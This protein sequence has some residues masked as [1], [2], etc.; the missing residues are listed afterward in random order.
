MNP[1]PIPWMGWGPLGPPERT[2]DASGSTGGEGF[3]HLVKVFFGEF[4]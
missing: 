4:H 3:Q 1:A 2:A